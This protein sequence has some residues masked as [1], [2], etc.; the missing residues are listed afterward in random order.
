MKKTLLA[1]LFACTLILTFA[2]AAC[3]NRGNNSGSSSV[4][5]SGS[6]SGYLSGDS[7][8]GSA[9]GGSS[10]GEDP[11]D[12]YA[13]YKVTADEYAAAFAADAFTNVT[14]TFN[15]TTENENSSL[16]DFLAILGL[17][18]NFTEN[19][20]F[21]IDLPNERIATF[22]EYNGLD[23][24]HIYAKTDDDYFYFYKEPNDEKYLKK[25]VDQDE[26]ET[27]VESV[28]DG[29]MFAM[30]DNAYASLSFD[31]ET[32]SYRAKNYSFAPY[33]DY[34]EDVI[35]LTELSVKFENGRLVNFTYTQKNNDSTEISSYAFSERGNTAI[36]LPSEDEY[37]DIYTISFETNNGVYGDVFYSSVYVP[38]SATYKI[39]GNK[40]TSG[41]IE[42]EAQANEGYVFDKWTV[43]G[44]EI[45][46]EGA[47]PGDCT[48]TAEFKPEGEYY[49]V[50]FVS[51]NEEY[52]TVSV[53]YLYVSVGAEYVVEEDIIRSGELDAIACA[54][55]GYVFDKWTVNGVE[56]AAEGTI[57][58]DCTVTALFKP[59]VTDQDAYY[60]VFPAGEYGFEVYDDYCKFEH[61]EESEYVAALEY[62]C[63]CEGDVIRI[64]TGAEENYIIDWNFSDP[65]TAAAA[66]S[67]PD[68]HAVIKEE[69]Y[70]NI[71][72][73][74]ND[75]G[76]IVKLDE[77]LDF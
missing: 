73:D 37:E 58:G 24:A 67:D 54:N 76:R 34:P 26:F 38:R 25:P 70:Y 42:V 62:A 46:P 18:F 56:L 19:K 69:G 10:S 45:A 71:F 20:T 49:T 60:L 31:E 44:E 64:R 16:L 22:T 48:I 13:A 52:G 29:E 43:N 61:A 8:S 35:E 15:S 57:L 14:V 9:N 65:D 11:T 66:T 55:L 1:I 51:D 2:L 6:S 74:E 12:E 33:P 39:V 28:F 68:G 7:S 77:E 21:L 4:S 47:V 32:S 41:K 50:T 72:V 23:Y 59:F 40:I 17:N 5:P 63:F 3:N 75:L 30:I 27:F 36:E 53:P